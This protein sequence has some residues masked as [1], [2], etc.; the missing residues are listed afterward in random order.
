MATISV[1][2]VNFNGGHYPNLAL[3]SLAAQTF[4]DF[5]VLFVDN[6][7]S[8]GSADKL[9]TDGIPAFKLIRS[10][11]NLG[12]AGGN[13][14]AAKQ[15]SGEWL[16]LLNPDAI[17][18]PEWLAEVARARV[19][20]KDVKMFASAQYSAANTSVMDGAGDAYL[21]FGMPWRG[22]YGRPVKEMPQTDCYCFSPCGAGAFFERRI[23]LDVGGFDERFFCFCEDVDLGFRL[24]LLGHDCVFLSQAVIQHYGGHSSDKVSEFA[25][26]HGGRNRIWTYVKNM[27]PFWLIVTLPGHVVLSIYLILH[28][29]MKGKGRSTARAMWAGISGLPELLTHN[30]WRI[31]RRRTSGWRL[32]RKMA[33]NPWKMN[34]RAIHVRS[35]QQSE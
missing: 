14:L 10:H 31:N 33:W 23:F 34:A 35:L 26:F 22:G 29:M 19:A 3:R 20:Y 30:T 27:P 32:L 15:A 4:R 25:T 18:S 28:A 17:A 5:E 13:N 7:S 2:I 12:F 21:I 1:I 16:A 6:A 8:D 9:E 11:E 24:Q